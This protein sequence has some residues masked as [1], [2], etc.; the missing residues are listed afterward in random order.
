MPFP[1]PNVSMINPKIVNSE[2]SPSWMNTND[3]IINWTKHWKE[4]QILSKKLQIITHPC[5]LQSARKIPTR[6]TIPWTIL[7][8]LHSILTTTNLQ[9]GGCLYASYL[10]KS[11]QQEDS[12]CDH[13]HIAKP[14]PHQHQ[15][16]AG[17]WKR[18]QEHGVGWL[19]G[20]AAGWRSAFEGSV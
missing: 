7:L 14:H 2:H 19:Q 13:A 6:Y 1:T 16:F 20:I 17:N 15:R 4:T 3:V 9:L 18:D 10:P 5:T 8:P 12:Q 11:L